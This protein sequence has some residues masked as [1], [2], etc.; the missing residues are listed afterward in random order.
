MWIKSY[1]KFNLITASTITQT[2]QLIFTKNSKGCIKLKYNCIRCQLNED[3][4]KMEVKLDHLIFER[5]GD[6]MD[7]EIIQLSGNIER[8]TAECTN[9]KT[10]RDSIA[11]SSGNSIFGCHISFYYYGLSHL[12]MNMC[13]YIASG[14]RKNELVFLSM[15]TDVF[16]KLIALLQRLNIPSESIYLYPVEEM[17]MLNKERGISVLKNKVDEFVNNAKNKGF[18]GIRW[19]GQP[20]YA[21]KRTSK[22]DFLEFE[23]ALT[24][25]VAD[26]EISVLCIYDSYDYVTA[27]KYIDED[28]IRES[29][30]THTHILGNMDID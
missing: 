2:C 6:L 21:M 26:K 22:S 15:E 12:I 18:S 13:S 28:V 24:E 8:Y 27:K 10:R 7:P 1:C 30:N 19:I 20:S 14:V 11:N 4:R 3:I 25:M 16:D 29:V 9:C 23:L 5:K 17:I